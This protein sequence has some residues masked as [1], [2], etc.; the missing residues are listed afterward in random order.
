MVESPVALVWSHWPLRHR[1]LLAILLAAFLI[2]LASLVFY[3][4]GWTW[5][6]GLLLVAFL[7]SLRDIL[8]PRNMRLDEA[9]LTVS[10][11]LTGAQAWEWR[12]IEALA[13]LQDRLQVRPRG[14]RA[15]WL[16]LPAELDISHLQAWLQWFSQRDDSDIR[17]A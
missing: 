13:L 14:K 12:Q 15:A 7:F 4:L 17:P 9:G 8:F 5:Q 10:H 6:G 11:P 16:P 1:P 2:L 3:W